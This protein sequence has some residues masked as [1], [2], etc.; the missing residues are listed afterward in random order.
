MSVDLL[1]RATTGNALTKAGKAMGV[2]L[3]DGSY[4]AGVNVDIIAKGQ[5]VI[6]PGDPPVVDNA[7]IYVN[8]RVTDPFPIPDDDVFI[9]W[10]QNNGVEQVKSSLYPDGPDRTR[11]VKDFGGG[12]V[13]EMIWPDPPQFPRRVWL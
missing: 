8:L 2:I 5:Y 4:A 7:H 6:T 1:F 13:V 12:D 10:M 3:G 11:W 9:N